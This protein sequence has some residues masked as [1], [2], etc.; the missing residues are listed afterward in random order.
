MKIAIVGVGYVGLVTGTCFSEMGM[1]VFCVDID[2]AKIDNLRKGIL[3]IYEPQLE[4]MVLKN[5]ESNRLHFTTDITSVLNDM[6]VVFCAVGTPSSDDGSADLTNVYAFADKI[7]ECL[8]KYLLI[9]TKSTV[10]VG[11]TLNIKK[12][13]RE[14][15]INRGLDALDFDVASN[16]EFLKEGTAVHDFMHPDR[17]VV[18][19]ENDR[20]KEVMDRLYKPFTINNYRMIYTDISSSEMIKYAANAMLATRISFMNDMANLCEIL[21]ADINSVRAGIGADERIGKKF[22]YAGCGYGGSCFPKDVRAIIKTAEENNY[23]LQ[24]LKAVE[25]VNNVQKEILFRKFLRYFNDNVKG[26]IVSIWGLAFK[27]KTDDIREA[28]SLALIDKLL[29]RGVSVKVYD[30][31]AMPEIKKKY[32]NKII[33]SKDIYDS[34]I[35]SDSIILVTEWNE[36]RLPSWMQIKQQMK[37]PVV[38]DGRNIYNSKE[39]RDLGF[40]YYSIGTK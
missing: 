35:D 32:G 2:Q 23:S 12:R 40:S 36:F 3:P 26:K 6:D 10:P 4:Q 1:D 38:L 25:N 37:T 5:Y 33:Y 28:P 24:V 34:V 13:I 30:P 31:V 18:G 19:V 27:P 11:T 17:V 20:A 8:N 9:V 39:L 15:L 22:L 29:S 7:G 14:K 21:G 16:P